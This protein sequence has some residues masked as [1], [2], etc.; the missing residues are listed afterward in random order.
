MTSKRPKSRSSNTRTSGHGKNKTSHPRGKTSAPPS[1]LRVIGGEWRSRKLAFHPAEGLRPTLDRVRETLFN[2]LGPYL[3]GA[4]CLDLFAGSGALSFEALSR[5]A[6]FMQINEM[7]PKVKDVI[8]QQLSLLNCPSDKYLLSNLD[9]C[10]ITPLS[11]DSAFDIVFIDPPFNKDMIEQCCL[12]LIEQQ[13]VHDQ[14]LIYI[15]SETDL[16]TLQL[17]VD[18]ALQKHKKAGQTHYGLFSMS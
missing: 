16:T 18:W 7:N 1:Q 14:T 11:P 17:P 2:W 13:L 3:T 8:Q 5:G 10:K 4:K 9:G 12:N 6:G 15:E